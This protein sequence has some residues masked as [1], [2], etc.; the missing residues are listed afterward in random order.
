MVKQ[1][2]PCPTCGKMPCFDHCNHCGIEIFWRPPLLD[3]EIVYRGPKPLTRDGSHHNDCMRHGTK[4]G[5]YYNVKQDLNPYPRAKACVILCPEREC[6]EAIV[7]PD[8]FANE[9]DGYILATD[10]RRHLQKQHG[11]QITDDFFEVLKWKISHL[12]NNPKYK[13]MDP[14]LFVSIDEIWKAMI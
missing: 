13:Y 10:F 5:N 7:D 3:K 4:D 1:R 2:Y 14:F 9:C 12:R 8:P 11:I 6:I